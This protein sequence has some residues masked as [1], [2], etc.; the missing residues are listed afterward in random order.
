MPPSQ[1]RCAALCR[2]TLPLPP[3]PAAHIQPTRL[4]PAAQYGWSG[5]LAGLDSEQ[6]ELFMEGYG[7]DPAW[8]A[9]GPALV[10][11]PRLAGGRLVV[12]LSAHKEAPKA[13]ENFRCGA[14]WRNAGEMQGGC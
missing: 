13:C 5:G 7:S 12:E 6:Q 4:P 11:E 8:A 10:A 9:K 2:R 1:R 3:P 14:S